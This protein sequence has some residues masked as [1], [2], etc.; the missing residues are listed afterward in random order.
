MTAFDYK[1]QRWVEGHEAAVLLTQQARE[2]LALLRSDRGQDYH[3]STRRDQTET[4]AARIARVV[5]FVKCD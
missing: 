4:L 2:E 5:R 1:A 3:V